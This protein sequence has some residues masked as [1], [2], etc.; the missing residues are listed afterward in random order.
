MP[1][2][3]AFFLATN[4]CIAAFN[5]SISLMASAKGILVRPWR[6][7]Y[8]ERV[9]LFKVQV[10]LGV[11]TR[12]RFEDLFLRSQ[13]V[14]KPHLIDIWLWSNRDETVRT[15]TRELGNADIADIGSDCQEKCSR[16]K[17]LTYLE[18]GFVE[19]LRIRL[20]LAAAAPYVTRLN[21]R[22]P[23]ARMRLP[24][25]VGAVPRDEAPAVRGRGP[26][27]YAAAAAPPHV[28]AQTVSPGRTLAWNGA[29]SPVS[30]VPGCSSRQQACGLRRASSMAKVFISWFCAALEAR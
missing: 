10:C 17:K 7:K 16:R 28:P 21:K 19:G 26:R 23:G 14:K 1:C 30:T 12:Y 5:S 20:D 15:C 24:G 8:R 2:L 13:R 27:S 22:L 25:N 11:V 29:D 6:N 9:Q 18:S 3:M 4:R